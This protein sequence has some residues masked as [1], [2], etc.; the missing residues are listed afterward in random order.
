MQSTDSIET[1]VYG[2]NKNLVSKKEK[3]KWNNIMKQ[4]RK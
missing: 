4:C 2:T 1:Y 3:I